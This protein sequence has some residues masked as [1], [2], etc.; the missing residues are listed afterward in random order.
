M[1]AFR[2]VAAVELVGH[3][4][5]CELALAVCY[6]RFV[7]VRQVGVVKVDLSVAVSGR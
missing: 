3:I 6:E 7:F 4:Y 5:V 1:Q 2:T